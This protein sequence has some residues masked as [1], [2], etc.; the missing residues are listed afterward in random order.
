[1]SSHAFCSARRFYLVHAFFY[2]GLD[3]IRASLVFLQ[4]STTLIFF[5]EAT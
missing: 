5:L 2:R 3:E 4:N 1:M